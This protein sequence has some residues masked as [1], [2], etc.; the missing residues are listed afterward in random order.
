MGA[1]TYYGPFFL[2]YNYIIL[3]GRDYGGMA[4]D[5]DRQTQED[6]GKQI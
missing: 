2:I 5:F 6:D 3:H 4:N 1:S